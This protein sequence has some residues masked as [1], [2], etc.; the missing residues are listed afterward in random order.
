M[1]AVSE[2]LGSPVPEPRRL[3]KLK[4]PWMETL[5][6]A[7]G[8][9]A[10]LS[11]VRVVAGADDLTAGGTFGAAVGSLC[12]SVGRARR[13]L[14]GARGHREH[15]SRRHDDH[16]HLV[17]AWAGWQWGPW[18]GVAI[19]ILGGML[20]GLLHAVA[21]VTFG[22]D[23]VVSGVAINILALGVTRYLATSVFTGQEDVGHALTADPWR[24]RRVHL[25][26]PVGR[27]AVR[28]GH[29]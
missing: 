15:R 25:S 4:W 21:T 17:R 29:A 5:I 20:G 28:L 2:P 12:P 22:V 11:L 9:F 10:V 24:R 26:L 14:R 7:L 23:H 1:T 6:F 16:G 27:A 8:V 19:G 13:S 3:P 18:A